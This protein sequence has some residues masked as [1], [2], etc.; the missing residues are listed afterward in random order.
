MFANVSL[1][2]LGFT[3]TVN[4]RCIRH[5]ASGV[6]SRLIWMAYA[7]VTGQRVSP[8]ICYKAVRC[9]PLQ[10]ISPW[11]LVCAIRTVRTSVARRVLHVLIANRLVVVLNEPTDQIFL[12]VV[13]LMTNQFILAF[14]AYAG[15]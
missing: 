2:S 7:D 14:E 15:F 4:R 9:I 5:V 1:T 12:A 10:N 11:I 13:K 8:N 3:D 6:I